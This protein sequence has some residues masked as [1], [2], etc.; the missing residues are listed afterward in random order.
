MTSP[1]RSPQSARRPFALEAA[2]GHPVARLTHLNADSNDEGATGV[3]AVEVYL[4]LMAEAPR[5]GVGVLEIYL[6]Y[7]PID[8]EVTAGLHSLYLD[9]AAGLGLLYL[10]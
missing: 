6:P 2:S 1:R 7:A 3:A 10:V 9:L 4:R 8:R 5:H